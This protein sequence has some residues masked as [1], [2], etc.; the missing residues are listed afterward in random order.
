[1]SMAFVGGAAISLYGA[2]QASK[3]QERSS[4]TIAASSDRAAQLQYDLGQR[5]LDFAERQYAEN[6]PMADRIAQTQVGI[7][8]DA[9]NQANDYYDYQKNT[10][11][12]L[13]Q[14]LVRDAENFSTAGAQEAFARNAV[15]DT[16]RAQENAQ[17]QASRAMAAMGVNPNSGRFAGMNK[18]MGLQNA[19]M[20]AGA[21]TN[22]RIQGEEMGVARRMN[23]AG[24]GRNLAANTTASQG[25]SVGAGSAGLNSTMAPGTAALT[26]MHNAGGTMANGGRFSVAGASAMAGQSN[27]Y[28]SLAGGVGGNLMGY[29]MFQHM[30]G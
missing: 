5:E 17:A 6:K 24:L 15:T 29:G 2:S 28:A 12:P 20:R 9:R 8:D 10:F 21:A 13:E 26:G 14:G 30:K 18:S 11:R 27:P 4:A 1:M 19:A 16:Q 23:A 7:M 25:M 3:A 22:A